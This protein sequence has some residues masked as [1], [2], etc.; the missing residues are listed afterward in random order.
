[1]RSKY[2]KSKERAAVICLGLILPVIAGA[3]CTNA[4]ADL[5]LPD[6]EVLVAHPVQPDVPLHHQWVATLDGYVNADIRPQVS[7]YI[8]AQ[9]Y[10][11]GTAV[12]KGQVLFEIDPRSAKARFCSKSIRGR[13]RRP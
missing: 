7:G 11:E 3:G 8:S 13:S 12:R 5:K 10:K 6:P 9:N 2:L 4:S 1:M